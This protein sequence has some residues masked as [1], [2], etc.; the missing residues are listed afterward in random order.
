MSA[1]LTMLGWRCCLV[2][3]FGTSCVSFLP[4]DESPKGNAEVHQPETRQAEDSFRNKV[5]KIAEIAD[6]GGTC[7]H[8]IQFINETDGWI[9]CD[10]QLWRST[11]GGQSWKRVD[12]TDQ[13]EGSSAYCFINTQVGWR[14]SA[15]E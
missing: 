9:S 15:S 11:S 1:K 3:L 12:P 6:Q 13:I 14:H 10:H 2:L 4:R 5:L 7:R 8:E